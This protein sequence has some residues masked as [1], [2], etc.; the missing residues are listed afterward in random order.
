VFRSS[1]VQNLGQ[2]ASEKWIDAVSQ[3]A[4]AVI[5]N[6]THIDI[7]DIE[8]PT[9]K[10]VLDFSL[11]IR[12]Y[13]SYQCKCG[14]YATQ[15]GTIGPILDGPIAPSIVLKSSDYLQDANGT[16]L[17]LTK[18]MSVSDIMTQFR[19]LANAFN[20]T[21]QSYRHNTFPHG[22]DYYTAMCALAL[23]DQKR[24]GRS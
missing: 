1:F 8:P 9:N 7:P 5:E 24:G 18:D 13:V 17:V 20:E 6:K 21:L 14:G 22:M 19:Q 4:Q 2:A 15:M 12:R 10:L 16:G 3:I 23:A 11:N